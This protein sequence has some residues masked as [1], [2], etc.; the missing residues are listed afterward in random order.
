MFFLQPIAIVDDHCLLPVDEVNFGLKLLA[1]EFDFA[2]LLVTAIA[3]LLDNAV[4]EINNGA[5]FVKLDRIYNKRDNSLA[6]LFL[7]G[8]GF[9]TSTMRLGA[10][11][12]VFSRASRKGPLNADVILPSLRRL[13]CDLVEL[14]YQDH[15]GSA[16]VSSRIERSDQKKPEN[17]VGFSNLDLERE[18][19]CGICLEPC[20]KI[21]LPNCCHPMCIN[22]YRDW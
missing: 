2:L 17:Q 12:I 18:D 8:D 4:H 5:T 15:S 6:L 7:D 10:D 21:V 9:K 13:H 16:G 1:I 11:V 14:D 3:E 20:T 22:C 19:E